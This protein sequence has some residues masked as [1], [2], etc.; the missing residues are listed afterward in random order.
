MATKKEMQ[1][2]RELAR[3]Y[4]N[5]GETQKTIAK[6][7]GVSEVTISKWVKAESWDI[8]RAAERVTRPELVNQNLQLIAALQRQV[9]DS[10]NPVKESKSV[11]DQISKLAAAIEK[12]DKKTNVIQIQEGF[13]LF[14]RWLQ[15]HPGLQSA[16][17][18]EFIKEL[19]K[20]Q[21]EYLDFRFKNK[22]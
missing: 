15:E 14:S 22:E 7:I 10:D 19:D 11:S 16:E 3:M 5:R 12:L 13:I 20:Y 21:G 9:I 8:K 6:R 4:Y 1:D 17:G 2:K 18:F